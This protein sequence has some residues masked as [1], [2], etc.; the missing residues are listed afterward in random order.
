MP[1]PDTKVRAQ[2][3][4]APLPGCDPVIGR[5]LAALQ[6]ARQ[7]TLRMVA[8][9]DSSQLDRALG[10]TSSPGTLLYHIAAI[11]IDWL[12]TDVLEGNPLPDALWA[13][14]PTDVRD[15]SGQLIPVNGDSLETHL[16][17]LDAVRAALIDA[18]RSMDAEEFRRPRAL[19][20]YDV[21]P[22]YVIHHLIQH[23]AEHR[24]EIG[25]VRA[26]LEQSPD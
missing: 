13:L 22:E 7:R 26:R 23:E 11:E 16:A 15:S 6:E 14:F 17:R 18:Y 24:A 2:H 10:S 19:P 8:G 9:L 3:I 1:T 12:Q 4:L 25:F 5:A 21:S 20:D